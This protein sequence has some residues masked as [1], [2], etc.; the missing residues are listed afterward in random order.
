MHENSVYF[1][2]LRGVAGFEVIT[3]G[4]FWVTRFWVTGDTQAVLQ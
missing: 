1:V 3:G 4:R 2:Q